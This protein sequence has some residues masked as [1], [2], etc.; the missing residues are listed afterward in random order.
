MAESGCSGVQRN[1]R[2]RQAASPPEVN[3]GGID[4]Q[5]HERDYARSDRL[6]L[7]HTLRP[8]ILG[9]LLLIVFHGAGE[10]KITR[11]TL[12]R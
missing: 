1:R 3:D 5:F 8:T 9:G 12:L 10:V 4:G 11:L 7:L 6:G 2:N